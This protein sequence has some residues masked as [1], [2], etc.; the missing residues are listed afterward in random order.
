MAKKNDALKKHHFWI[1]AG[2][3]PLFVLLAVIF[4]MT[5]V[6]SAISKQQ[7]EIKQS[8]EAVNKASPPGEGA[9]KELGQQKEVLDKKKGELWK[10]NWERQKV[11]FT[12]P[13]RPEFAKYAEVP[14][15]IGEELLAKAAKAKQDAKK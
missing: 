9:L 7:A 2:L 6:S 8:V 1:L 3:A 12:W 15:N 10:E 5:G 14:S 11:F 13:P 4:L